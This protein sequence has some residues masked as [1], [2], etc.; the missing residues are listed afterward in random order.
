MGQIKT[1]ADLQKA[2][3]A[4]EQK[5]AAAW[6]LL[7]EQFLKTAESLKLVNVLKSTF[8]EFIAAPEVK[9][10]VVNSVVG[11]ATGFVAKKAIVGNTHNPL[12]KLLGFILEMTVA[13][14]V[15]RN[16]EMI[17]TVGG[18]LINKVTHP[19]HDAKEE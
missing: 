2:I 4:L 3:A 8:K 6:P 17:K 19:K 12:K 1:T 18:I 14:G 5:Q 13:G 16:A 7:E 15:S 10:G 9:T 11:L